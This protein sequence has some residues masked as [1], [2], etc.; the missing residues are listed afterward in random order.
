[1]HHPPFMEPST[2]GYGIMQMPEPELAWSPS[3]VQCSTGLQRRDAEECEWDAEP[4]RAWPGRF[5]RWL[6][7]K[8]HR[9]QRSQGV[10]K[11]IPNHPAN[12]SRP[13]RP[14]GPQRPRPTR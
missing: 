3:P 4:P 2:R 13:T 10:P 6:V 11:G 12:G 7:S 5:L 1:M 9:Y 14:S 8:R